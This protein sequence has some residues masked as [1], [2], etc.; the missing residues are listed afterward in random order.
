MALVPFTYGLQL[1]LKF[2]KDSD[3]NNNLDCYSLNLENMMQWNERC[4]EIEK[5]SLSTS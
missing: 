2:C 3:D 4:T 1:Q 5:S